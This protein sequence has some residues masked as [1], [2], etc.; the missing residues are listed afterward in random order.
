MM[1]LTRPKVAEGGAKVAVCAVKFMAVA[2]TFAAGEIFFAAVAANIGAG[3]TK[4]EG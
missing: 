1:P 3:D 2:A 4:D